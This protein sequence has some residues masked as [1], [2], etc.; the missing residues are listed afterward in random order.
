VSPEPVKERATMQ[1][2]LAPGVYVEEID[3]GVKPIEGV[4]TSTAGFLGPTERGPVAEQFITSFTQFTQVYGGF[5]PDSY[6]A[7]AVDGF[8]RNGGQRCFIGRIAGANAATAEVDLGPVRAR[9]V[10]P[11][12]WGNRVFVK[13]ENASLATVA[14]PELFKLTVY[15]WR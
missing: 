4:S 10:G 1:E 8:F 13:V 9:A 14:R 3:L 6:L 5:L 15:Y 12:T 11:G 7:Y 2:Y